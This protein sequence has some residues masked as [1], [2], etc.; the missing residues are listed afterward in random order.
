MSEYI[1]RRRYIT[2]RT[3]L[4][5]INRELAKHQPSEK[6]R[7]HNRSDRRYDPEFVPYFDV[8][9]VGGYIHGEAILA[10]AEGRCVGADHRALERFA[11]E[12]GIHGVT[13]IPHQTCENCQVYRATTYEP[14]WSLS[15][16]GECSGELHAKPLREDGRHPS[17]SDC[18]KERV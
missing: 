15:L 5:Y 3:M 17:V 13:I 10:R 11:R 6:L 14:D 4:R 8:A 1:Q 18:R 9:R 12:L 2:R 7:Y 16:C